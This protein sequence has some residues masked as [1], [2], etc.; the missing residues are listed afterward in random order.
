MY[1]VEGSVSDPIKYIHYKT[2]LAPKNI[3]ERLLLL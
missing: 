1:V 3:K 2:R